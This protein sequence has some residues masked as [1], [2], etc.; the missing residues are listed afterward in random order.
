MHMSGSA[1]LPAD[2]HAPPITSGTVIIGTHFEWKIMSSKTI[3]NH[4]LCK[5]IIHCK[6]TLTNSRRLAQLWVEGTYIYRTPCTNCR[7]C[8]SW[9]LVCMTSDTYTLHAD[10]WRPARH[11]RRWRDTRRP[12]ATD[13]HAVKD[14]YPRI[15]IRDTPFFSPQSELWRN[16]QNR[17]NLFVCE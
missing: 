13:L 15:G 1:Q 12:I 17:E 14:L 9:W 7:C 16:S 5:Y 4:S 2:E 3:N 8:L 10:T 6:T 11:S